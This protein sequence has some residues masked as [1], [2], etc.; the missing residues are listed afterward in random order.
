MHPATQFCLPH[1]G[2]DRLRFSVRT[3][4]TFQC[5][6]RKHRIP[7]WRSHFQDTGLIDYDKLSEL[8]SLFK[9]ALL[10]CGG[11]AYPREWDYKR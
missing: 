5:Q 4:D 8:A 6:H 2:S 11:S 1:D 10:I 9:P 7:P 3:H